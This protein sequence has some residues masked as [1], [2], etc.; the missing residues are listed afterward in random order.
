MTVI[1]RIGGLENRLAQNLGYLDVIHR[2][3]GLESAD[4]RP[5]S[6][7]IVIHRIGGL[8]NIIFKNFLKL[9]CYTPHRWL[10]N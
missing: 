4:R 1:H 10:R 5:L 7:K 9:K 8:E 6:Y 2:I 3:G